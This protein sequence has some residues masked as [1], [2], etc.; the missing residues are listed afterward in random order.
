MT[1]PAPDAKPQETK[2]EIIAQHPPELVTSTT[3][4]PGIKPPGFKQTMIET[5]QMMM[6]GMGGGD[7]IA[8]K[9]NDGH[10]TTLIANDEKDSQRD[11]ILSIV[12]VV[13][14]IAVLLIVLAF[15][16][17]FCWLFAVASPQLVEKVLIGI[18]SFAG[19]I[20]AGLG[21][22]RLLSKMKD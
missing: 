22:P 15:V 6:M 18:I 13:G 11:Y 9:L 2:Q 1:D 14:L 21:A 20:G 8:S 12:K 7:P 3:T 5:H 17:L 4:G 19:G 10:I 16:V